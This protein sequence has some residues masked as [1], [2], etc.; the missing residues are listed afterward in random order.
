MKRH[1]EPRPHGPRNG[2]SL[3]PP[4]HEGDDS[5]AEAA[6]GTAVPETVMLCLIGYHVCRGGKD[7]ARC[8]RPNGMRTRTTLIQRRA[9]RH[10]Y[11]ARPA[12]RTTPLLAMG[13]CGGARRSG[14][15][16]R[17]TAFLQAN[18]LPLDFGA[19]RNI[20]I[21]DSRFGGGIRIHRPAKKQGGEALYKKNIPT[22]LFGFAL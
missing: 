19:A 9:L 21:A 16:H 7:P 18:F 12:H 1:P 2:A 17:Q 14:R 13:I 10:R 5:R 20:E 4:L 8:P 11:S 3:T 22:P 6:S 15:L